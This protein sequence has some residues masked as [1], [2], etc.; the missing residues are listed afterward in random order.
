MTIKPIKPFASKTRALVGEIIPPD[1]RGGGIKNSNPITTFM[2][3][4]SVG[5]KTRD[6]RVETSVNITKAALQLKEAETYRQLDL[7]DKRST[8]S[9]LTQVQDL[10]VQ[11]GQHIGHALEG[12]DETGFGIEMT[13]NKSSQSREKLIRESTLSEDRKADLLE[14]EATRAAESKYVGRRWEQSTKG[15][16]IKH[17]IALSDVGD[18]EE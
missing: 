3:N 13:T 15:A 12:I 2:D 8:S 18:N 9:Y 1:V 4:M 16:V 11:N 6:A 5:K 14:R 10:L 7:L 17:S